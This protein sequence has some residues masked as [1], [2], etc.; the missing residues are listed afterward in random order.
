MS[1]VAPK[2]PPLEDPTSFERGAV[3]PRTSD[4]QPM[5]IVPTLAAMDRAFQ[6]QYAYLPTPARAARSPSPSVSTSPTEAWPAY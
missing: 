6:E 5:P 3:R 2:R 4:R 1:G